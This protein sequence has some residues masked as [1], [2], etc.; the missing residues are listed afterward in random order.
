MAEQD[1]WAYTCWLIRTDSYRYCGRMGGL[2]L[3]RE[4]W[5]SP[6][7]LCTMW[8]RV[9][10]YLRR[11]Y[12]IRFV[13][14]II[15]RFFYFHYQYKYGICVP[16]D[17]KIGSGLYIGH[18]GGIFINSR[19]VLG[20]DVNLSQDVTLGGIEKGGQVVAPMVGDRVYIGPGAKL[21]GKV[22]IGC[23]V[24][25]GA[26][27]VVTKDAADRTVIAGIPGKVLSEGKGSIEYIQNTSYTD[28]TV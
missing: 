12:D 13:L 3:F 1:S 17:C 8:Y 23:D 18:F 7:L 5:S 27:C 11:K 4:L 22:T 19:C 9:C 26:N 21:V 16:Y 2:H 20:R 25:I 10:K 28:F 14:F 6:G 24:A 15:A